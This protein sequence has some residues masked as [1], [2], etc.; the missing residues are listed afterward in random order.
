M[1]GV[2]IHS[3]ILK[4]PWGKRDLR[5]VAAGGLVEISELNVTVGE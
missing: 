3:R 2:V 1:G 5:G 4:R